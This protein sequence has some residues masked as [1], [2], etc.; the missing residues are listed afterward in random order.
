[1][2]TGPMIHDTKRIEAIRAGT[3][4][5]IEREP[6]RMKGELLSA[7]QEAVDDYARAV[8]ALSNKLIT[9]SRAEFDKLSIVSERARRHALI[10]RE[11]YEAHVD[12]HGC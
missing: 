11:H 7:Q 8:M 2:E 4:A 12:E 9:L 3:M 10:A 6:C 5:Q 1:M